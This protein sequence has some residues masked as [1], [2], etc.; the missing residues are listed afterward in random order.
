L[1]H[2]NVTDD[3][4]VGPNHPYVW[5][6]ASVGWRVGACG[7]Q[8]V[9]TSQISP[10]FGVPPSF[11]DLCGSVN[12][13]FLQSTVA[14]EAVRACS[15]YPVGRLTECPALKVG[16]Y[17]VGYGNDWDTCLASLVFAYL[18]PLFPWFSLPLLHACVCT[19]CCVCCMCGV[20]CVW[21]S[22]ADVA[23]Q[24]TPTC[25]RMVTDACVA[26]YDTNPPYVCSKTVP[27]DVYTA[28]G[29]ALGN[30]QVGRIP[31]GPSTWM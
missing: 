2:G 4:Y 7:G 8:L 23:K 29:A 11:T 15:T 14:T 5:K 21:V 12:G 25:R 30:A 24:A 20:L 10:G 13:Y 31:A 28:V 16:R 26:S 19:R 18:T 9:N 27:A 1:A 17:L 3:P 22:Q 6:N